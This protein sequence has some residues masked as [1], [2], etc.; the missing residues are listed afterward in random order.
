MNV[1]SWREQCIPILHQ[2]DGKTKSCQLFLD[3]GIPINDQGNLGQLSDQCNTSCH[4][5]RHENPM[6]GQDIF[7]QE[8]HVRRWRRIRRRRRYRPKLLHYLS[9]QAGTVASGLVATAT[10]A[11]VVV[12]VMVVV[13]FVI[14]CHDNNHIV[15]GSQ[16]IKDAG[17]TLDSTSTT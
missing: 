3:S 13:G 10:A 12:V 11:A 17:Y 15:K 1:V 2:G 5:G 9:M 14:D 8:R 16:C 4:G 7:R 6:G